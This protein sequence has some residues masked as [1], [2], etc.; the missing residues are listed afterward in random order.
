MHRKGPLAR[1][2]VE[3]L[4]RVGCALV[5]LSHCG[6]WSPLKSYSG[7]TEQIE[8][9]QH[10][11]SSASG[12]RGLFASPGLENSCNNDSQYSEVL[13]REEGGED[14][15]TPWALRG[16]SVACEVSPSQFHVAFRLK[17]QARSHR[18]LPCLCFY[19]RWRGGVI[20]ATSEFHQ[21][22]L[23]LLLLFFFSFPSA[24][25]SSSSSFC[26]LSFFLRFLL[27]VIRLFAFVFLHNSQSQSYRLAY[28]H[29][30]QLRGLARCGESVPSDVALPMFQ[31]FPS[32]SLQSSSL[33]FTKCRCQA[34]WCLTQFKSCD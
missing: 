30:F 14:P 34:T 4:H 8:K 33:K 20:T 17:V 16:A 29:T 9:K 11:E 27:L 12:G 5:K 32:K 24:S 13:E 25:H 7:L 26:F 19:F 10:R 22:T 15:G 2:L 28:G 21:T 23:L 31:V 1:L 3:Q 18:A 6:V